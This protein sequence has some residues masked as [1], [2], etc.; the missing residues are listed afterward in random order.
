MTSTHNSQWNS[1]AGVRLGH[2][3]KTRVEWLW[4]VHARF[5]GSPAG[6]CEPSQ[7]QV[8]L[9]RAGGSQGCDGGTC[10][11]LG[12]ALMDESMAS[13]GGSR[14]HIGSG[15]RVCVGEVL[16]G[17]WESGGWGQ[18]VDALSGPICWPFPGGGPARLK[19]ELWVG[20]WCEVSEGRESQLRLLGL[21]QPLLASLCTGITLGTFCVG[22]AGESVAWPT[23]FC[24]P[25]SPFLYSGET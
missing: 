1:F 15:W 2:P 3:R 24:G 7:G 13:P 11:C 5:L 18:P 12:E 22:A 8:E 4:L 21:W 17:P 10:T 16:Q 9:C 14:V 19:A 23:P 25:L 6:L 20:S